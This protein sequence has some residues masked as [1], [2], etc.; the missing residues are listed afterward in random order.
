MNRIT[1]LYKDKIEMEVGFESHD[2]KNYQIIIKKLEKYR[3]SLY[4]NESFEEEDIK[5]FKIFNVC[6]SYERNY[7][8]NKDINTLLHNKLIAMEFKTVESLCGIKIPDSI[9]FLELPDW[10][11]E[12]IEIYPSK[13]IYLK[14]GRCF[15]Q[16][17]DNLPASLKILQLGSH[18][19]ESVSKLPEGLEYLGIPIGNFKCDLDGLPNNLKILDFGKEEEEYNIKIK[20]NK[21]PENLEVLRLPGNYN[22][23]LQEL[24]VNLKKL[25]LGYNYN[26]KITQENIPKNLEE[27]FLGQNYDKKKISK[28]ILSQVVK[29]IDY[30]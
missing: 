2:I 6:E 7:K 24:P 22:K 12:K 23:I 5:N 15:D 27:L 14:T 16:P 9:L 10:F 25:Y 11:N 28:E 29:I 13:L 21:L 20:L 30:Y 8:D 1:S 18:F 3:F 4:D 19:N 26:E 17:V